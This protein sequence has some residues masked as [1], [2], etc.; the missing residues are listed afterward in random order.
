LER[1]VG[2]AGGSGKAGRGTIGGGRERLSEAVA[3]DGAG[4]NAGVGWGAICPRSLIA[5]SKSPPTSHSLV[6]DVD[7]LET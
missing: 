1:D 4:T 5:R 7:C 2:R 3:A 6:V